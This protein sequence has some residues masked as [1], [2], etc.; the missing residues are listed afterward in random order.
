MKIRFEHQ[1]IRFRLQQTDLDTLHQ[2]GYVAETVYFP[3]GAL[4]FRLEVEHSAESVWA[5]LLDQIIIVHIPPATAHQWLT[6]E[7]IGIYASV[8]T[9]QGF[10]KLDIILEKDLPCEHDSKPYQAK[11][12]TERH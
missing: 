8:N 2:A 5:D 3:S 11:N 10:Q 7:D 12:P 4:V 9:V 6:S 1:S